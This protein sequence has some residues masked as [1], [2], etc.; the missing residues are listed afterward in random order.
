[1]MPAVLDIAHN[2]ADIACQTFP[3]GLFGRYWKLRYVVCEV[4]VRRTPSCG[5]EQ[6]T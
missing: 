3:E 5:V 6:A 2:G 1:V 4:I